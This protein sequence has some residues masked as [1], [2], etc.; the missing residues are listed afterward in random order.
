MSRVVC[1]EREILSGRFRADLKVYI[2]AT[3][4]LEHATQEGFDSVYKDAEYARLAFERSRAALSA[5]IA[6]HRCEAQW[7]MPQ[8]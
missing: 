2:D 5:H 4:R 6:E 3:E 8:T 7:S 1:E